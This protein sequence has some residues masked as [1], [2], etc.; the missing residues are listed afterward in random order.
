MTKKLIEI[1]H[2]YEVS[3]LTNRIKYNFF[4]YVNHIGTAKNTNTYIGT[5]ILIINYLQIASVIGSYVTPN[6]KTDIEILDIVLNYTVYAKK[7]DNKELKLCTIIIFTKI[8]LFGFLTIIEIYNL[9]IKSRDSGMNTA[10]LSYF[11]IIQEW[12]L[13]L[14]VIFTLTYHYQSNPTTGY[15]IIIILCLIVN[16]SSTAIFSYF[17][18]ISNLVYHDYFSNFSISFS[19]NNFLLKVLIYGLYFI[20]QSNDIYLMPC[21]CITFIAGIAITRKSFGKVVLSYNLFF[22]FGYIIGTFVIYERVFNSCI[23]N[24]LNGG[25]SFHSVNSTTYNSNYTDINV[26]NTESNDSSTSIASSGNGINST[27][28]DLA[29]GD[30]FYYYTELYIPFIIILF[31]IGLIMLKYYYDYLCKISI[32]SDYTRIH[33]IDDMMKFFFSLQIIKNYDNSDRM[34]VIIKEGLIIKYLQDSN[35][36]AELKEFLKSHSKKDYKIYNKHLISLIKEFLAY[37]KKKY[38]NNYEFR[39]LLLYSLI[40]IVDNLELALCEIELTKTTCTLTLDQEYVLYLLKDYINERLVQISEINQIISS[41]NTGESVQ[42]ENK[43]N[44]GNQK[45][46]FTAI[47]NNYKQKSNAL[48]FDTKW[49][50]TTLLKV[51]KYDQL[52]EDLKSKVFLCYEEKRKLWKTLSQHTIILEDLYSTAKKYFS[53]KQEAKDIWKDLLEHCND[54]VDYYITHFYCRFL[55][56]ICQEEGESERILDKRLKFIVLTTPDELYN[57]KFKG[58]TGILILDVFNYGSVSGSIIHVNSAFIENFEINDKK[59]ILNKNVSMLMPKIV[60][61][62][63]DEIFKNYFNKGYS[64]IMRKTLNFLCIRN[65]E[66]YLIPMINALT[67][68]PCINESILGLGLFRRKDNADEVIICDREGRIDSLSRKISEVFKLTPL[69][70]EKQSYYIYSYLPDLLRPSSSNTIIPKFFNE[71]AFSLKRIEEKMYCYIPKE[72]NINKNGTKSNSKVTSVFSKKSIPCK[73]SNNYIFITL[74]S[75]ISANKTSGNTLTKRNS[76]NKISFL[77]KLLISKKNKLQSS[78]NAVKTKS[79]N[80]SVKEYNQINNNSLDINTINSIEIIK[81]IFHSYV[82]KKKAYQKHHQEQMDL[83]KTEFVD[84]NDKINSLKHLNKQRKTHEKFKIEEKRLL[85]IKSVFEKSITNHH[86]FSSE[87]K[88]IS[89]NYIGSNILNNVDTLRTIFI[90][91]EYFNQ[92]EDNNS[93]YD[94]KSHSTYNVNE[95]DKR[96]TRREGDDD[97]EILDKSFKNKSIEA[98]ETGSTAKIKNVYYFEDKILSMNKNVKKTNFQFFFSGIIFTTLLLVMSI[99]NIVFINKSIVV[100][101]KHQIITRE[102]KSIN[103]NFL[104]INNN[105]FKMYMIN[106]VIEISNDNLVVNKTSI[107]ERYG[108]I[109]SLILQV[110]NDNENTNTIS[111]YHFFKAITQ[112]YPLYK[113]TYNIYNIEKDI[114]TIVNNR[115][116]IFNLLSDLSQDIIYKKYLYGFDFSAN[117]IDYIDY[118]TTKDNS[119]SNSTLYSNVRIPDIPNKINLL[120]YM[121]LLDTVNQVKTQV[122]DIL[123]QYKLYPSLNLSLSLITS[124]SEEVIRLI[125]TTSNFNR[126]I[127]ALCLNNYLD[128]LFFSYL[129]V[130]S[131]VITV[132]T[133]LVYIWRERFKVKYYKQFKVLQSF[134]KIKTAEIES[135]FDSLNKY[136]AYNLNLFKE[137]DEF[138]SKKINVNIGYLELDNSNEISEPEDDYKENNVEYRNNLFQV[139]V[140]EEQLLLENKRI[141]NVNMYN[142]NDNNKKIE[143]H[144]INNIRDINNININLNKEENNLLLHNKEN[145]ISRKNKNKAHSK[146][147]YSKTITFSWFSNSLILIYITNTLVLLC[148]IVF[149]YFAR[150]YNYNKINIGDQINSSKVLMEALVAVETTMYLNIRLIDKYV[151][152]FN[153]NTFLLNFTDNFNIEF[154]NTIQESNHFFSD[155]SKN[156]M[157]KDD[158]CS[159]AFNVTLNEFISKKN[160]TNVDI[161]GYNYSEKISFNIFSKDYDYSDI[162]GIYINI[163]SIDNLVDVMYS[164]YKS[165]VNYFLENCFFQNN[166]FYVK[167]SNNEISTETTDFYNLDNRILL[168]KRMEFIFKEPFILNEFIRDY[169]QFIFNILTNDFDYTTKLTED[170]FNKLCIIFVVVSNLIAIC[171]TFNQIIKVKRSFENMELLSNKIISEIPTKVLISNEYLMSELKGVLEQKK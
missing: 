146:L 108:Y 103:Y 58:D 23:V 110:V 165:I 31:M 6:T 84:D 162:H 142:I 5:L 170:K 75:A 144:D 47:L 39:I 130:S 123:Y 13:F 46:D 119:Y 42:N 73:Y 71:I 2:N 161:D 81:Q 56:I 65:S 40:Y 7:L 96:K 115:N 79:S 88:E 41:I 168:I 20:C 29:N 157:Q 16:F 83:L 57:Y 160:L 159:D 33:S 128:T 60:G 125:K 62:R 139:Q 112:L 35:Q 69:E 155:I 9:Y 150:K 50:T 82:E 24:Y 21:L 17:S 93:I 25:F 97:D 44:K 145:R 148:N 28:N 15:K 163:C 86:F 113:D 85:F 134:E 98:I 49:S 149:A 171:I 141:E 8:L 70:I 77:Q 118:S 99:L 45:E 11:Y 133:I 127:T 59:E 140:N 147:L 48:F 37:F 153:S 51:Y 152:A 38:S 10:V 43:G 129:I 64:A 3:S 66:K 124:I 169:I 53:L 135:I 126:N 102:I 87:R 19:L 1:H 78:K 111:L 18:C 95:E 138:K 154:T 94:Y 164:G 166:D 67:I 104:R 91:L 32:V 72:V 26:T 22:S 54:N 34:K 114:E 101:D 109:N 116:N 120:T 92:I 80:K 100:S 151:D 106:E 89:F 12:I 63:H 158:L 55:K 4:N 30:L 137:L 27:T 136:E 36:I 105:L 131:I 14:P 143:E 107:L 156:I 52:Y 61:N 132:Y 122:T 90:P 167:I 76:N 121:T 68:L 74:L 117:F